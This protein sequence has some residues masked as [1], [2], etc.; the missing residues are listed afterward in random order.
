MNII[1]YPL[2]IM[3][4][5]LLGKA[6]MNLDYNHASNTIKELKTICQKM[7]GNFIFL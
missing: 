6:A 3:D 5:S 2:I 7:N 1:E 4:E